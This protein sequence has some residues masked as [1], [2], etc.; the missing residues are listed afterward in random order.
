ME[1]SSL[2]YADACKSKVCPAKAQCNNVPGSGAVC[3]CSG[4]TQILK[5]NAC[6]DTKVTVFKVVELKFEEPYDQN[7]QNKSSQQFKAKAVQL[8]N[9]LYVAVCSKIFG[10]VA[11]HVKDIRKGS[12]VVDY[13]LVVDAA[14]KNVTVSVVQNATIAGLDD[15]ALALFKPNK[16]SRPKAQSK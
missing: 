1:R 11:I 14:V 4:I 6:V 3:K 8:E 12:I 13:D 2:F 9:A 15:P 5:N 7:Y 16:T 10:C